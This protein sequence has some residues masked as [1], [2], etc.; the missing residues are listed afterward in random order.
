MFGFRYILGYEIASCLIPPDTLVFSLCQLGHL[1]LF[2]DSM[3][4]QSV[5]WASVSEWAHHL[6]P[7][8]EISYCNI[9]EAC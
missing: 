1:H 6:C 2:H 9:Q 4:N 8:A 7:P 3:C 5:G